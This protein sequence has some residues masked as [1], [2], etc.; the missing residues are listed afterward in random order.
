MEELHDL[1]KQYYAALHRC[2]ANLHS[3]KKHKP[4]ELQGGMA[5]PVP[6]ITAYGK[7][8]C[9]FSNQA[10]K[11]LDPLAHGTYIDMEASGYSPTASHVSAIDASATIPI[12]FV[13]DKYIG[14]LDELQKVV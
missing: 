14:G 11:L 4:S 12:V 9:H 6:A 10:Q 8:Y 3:V 1:V 2:S 7:S 13:G 5:S